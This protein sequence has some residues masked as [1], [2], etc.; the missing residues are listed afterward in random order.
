MRIRTGSVL[1]LAGALL[2]AACSTGTSDQPQDDSTTVTSTTVPAAHQDTDDVPTEGDEPIVNAPLP[3][4]PP[5]STDRTYDGDTYPTELTGLVTGA[6]ADLA[7]RLSADGGS[8][9]VVSL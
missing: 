1:L 4:T 5:L 3:T 9:L 2:V 7:D 6:V 8:I